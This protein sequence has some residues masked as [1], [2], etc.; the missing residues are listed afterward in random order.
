MVIKSANN[1]SLTKKGKRQ[2]TGE[3]R[4]RV[5]IET[6]IA[7]RPKEVRKRELFGH[8]ELDAAPS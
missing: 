8:W 6:P 1:H 2:K 5:N 4:G 3:K 7:K